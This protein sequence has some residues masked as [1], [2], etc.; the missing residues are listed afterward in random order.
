VYVFKK[1]L[2]TQLLDPTV[3]GTGA[4]PTSQICTTS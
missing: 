4:A 3:N 2:P 1:M